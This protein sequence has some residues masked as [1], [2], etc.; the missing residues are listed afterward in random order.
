M[1]YS[2]PEPCNVISYTLLTLRRYIFP[3]IFIQYESIR[4]EKKDVFYI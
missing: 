1:V 4:Y 3:S 2:Y